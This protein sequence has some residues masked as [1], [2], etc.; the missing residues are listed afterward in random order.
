MW[1]GAA[2]SYRASLSKIVAISSRD[3]E[4]DVLIDGI[5]G[6]L[7]FMIILHE[8][9]FDPDSAPVIRVDSTA[10]IKGAESD[11]VSRETRYQGMRMAF[12]RKQ[13]ESELVAL[14]HVRTGANVAD[15]FTKV[16]M[17]K[18][19]QKFRK[20]VMGHIDYRKIQLITYKK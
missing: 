18:A 7:G 17:S 11:S 3:A 20:A 15:V 1:C 12:V 16:L 9:G 4:L 10:T 2:F 13:V 14:E 8:L 6:T 19:F 5:K